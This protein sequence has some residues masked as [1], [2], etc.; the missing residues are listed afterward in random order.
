MIPSFYPPL[1]FPSSLQE[2]QSVITNPPLAIQ[3]KYALKLTGK[4][5]QA[6]IKNNSVIEV[7][8]VL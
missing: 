1:V 7:V 6:A 4:A 5:L 3:V 2:Q 8:E